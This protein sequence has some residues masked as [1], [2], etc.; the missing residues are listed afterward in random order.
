MKEEHDEIYWSMNFDKIRQSF[1]IN[2]V[3]FYGNSKNSNQQQTIAKHYAH[4]NSRYDNLAENFTHSAPLG[5]HKINK[6]Y[7]FLHKRTQKLCQGTVSNFKKSTLG[8]VHLKIA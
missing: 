3:P 8:W 4:Y 7:F 5:N 2:K 1:K 6:A